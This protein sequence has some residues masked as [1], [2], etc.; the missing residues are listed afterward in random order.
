[1]TSLK[2]QGS[3][4]QLAAGPA[5]KSKSKLT[6]STATMSGVRMDAPPDRPKSE[7]PEAPEI[8]PLFLTELLME[9]G[10]LIFTPTK[11]QFLVGVS[12]LLTKLRSTS[13][14]VEG[15]V[16]DEN[17]DAFTQWVN[18]ASLLVFDCVVLYGSVHLLDDWTMLVGVIGLYNLQEM[19]SEGDH[20][21]SFKHVSW[22]T[23]HPKK[24]DRFSFNCKIA[25]K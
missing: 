6:S 9:P 19:N 25:I 14:S 1:M 13:L 7:E 18:A 12:S 10:A 5:S 8:P 24:L 2:P 3:K 16:G 20:C 17:F 15:L 21:L 23:F 11:D 4:V 22:G